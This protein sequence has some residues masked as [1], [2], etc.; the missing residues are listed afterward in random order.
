MTGV[1]YE[2][3]L[4]IDGKGEDPCSRSFALKMLEMDEPEKVPLL[5]EGL[6]RELGIYRAIEQ[7]KQE[8]KMSP[9]IVP[10]CYGLFKAKEFCILVTEYGG[11]AM[12][13]DSWKS[14]AFED[15]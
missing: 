12:N 5:L 1:V 10:R 9:D 8:G 2:G 14:L 13:D 15:K 7:A 4:D 3:K 11:R 6:N